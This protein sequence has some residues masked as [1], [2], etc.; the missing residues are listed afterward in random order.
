MRSAQIIWIQRY[1]FSSRH[2]GCV[3]FHTFAL[4]RH[5]EFP[6]IKYLG[7]SFLLLLVFGTVNAQITIRGIV[8]DENHIPIPYATIYIENTTTGTSTNISGEFVITAPTDKN[9]L[10]AR[11]VGYKQYRLDISSIPHDPIK[12]IL[13]KEVFAIEQVVITRGEDPANSIIRNA[14]SQRKKYL[15]NNPAHTAKVYIK[16]VQRLL[17]APEKFLGIN[18]DEIGKELGLDSNRTGIIYLSESESRITAN[19]PNLFKEEMISSKIAGNNRS[20][21]FNR[22]SDLQINFYENHLNII[23][24]LSARPFISPIADNAFNYYRYQYLGYQ[25]E[26]GLSINKIR[27]IPRRKGEP[28]FSGDIYIVEDSWRI[29][30][31]NLLLTKE[32]SINIVDTLSIQQEHIPLVDGNWMPA[33]TNFNFRGGLLGFEIGGNFT[34]IFTDYQVGEAFPKNTFREILKIEQG[35]NLKDS[36][37]WTSNRPITLTEEERLDYIKKDSLSAHRASPDYLDSLDKKY[38]KFRPLGF[39]AGGYSYRNRSARTSLSFDAPIAAIGFNTVEGTFI[40]YQI[41]YR[42]ELDEVTRK[43]FSLDA[44][45]RYGFVNHGFNAYLSSTF[46]IGHHSTL[47]IAGGS[48]VNDLNERN[49]FSAL[50]NSIYTLFI[51]QNY[52]KLYE[53]DFGKM[54]WN[55]HLPGNIKLTASAVLERRKWLENSS[56]FSFIAEKHRNFTPNNPYLQKAPDRIEPLFSN[57]RAAHISVG[58]AYDFSNKYESLPSGKRYLPSK[59]PELSVNY[60]K[61]IKNI[62]RSSVDYDLFQASLTKT[63]TKLGIYGA[64]SYQLKAGKFLNRSKVFYP[65][66]L[67]L[68]STNFLVGDQQLASFLLVDPYIHSTSDY[69]LELHTEYNLSG[70]LTS[71]IPLLR[72]LN[73]QEIIGVHL[74]KTSAISNYGE[75][76]TGLQWQSVRILYAW[77]CGDHL[78]QQQLFGHRNAIRLGIRF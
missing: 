37:Y 33:S 17:K 20:F 58:L 49:E 40:N 67:H 62:F 21:S 72:R 59:Y 51:G 26:N 57:H 2:N 44:N 38:N 52:L 64:L 56:T 27:V 18:I 6:M 69:V 66:L 65:D 5:I 76:H 77:A 19:P 74:L 45:L 53:K 34:A 63:N 8:L 1:I 36:S 73:L 11:A 75:L 30:S 35:V 29:Y 60:T 24:G 31:V 43:N 48:T 4:Y 39:L 12:I 78:Q 15:Q 46:P 41:R 7:L 42:K 10:L 16:G 32:S 55:Y 13:E 3:K 68:Q 61:G 47:Q 50:L 22:A 71:K 14:I 9:G 54:I 25:E 28:V 70:I 23:D